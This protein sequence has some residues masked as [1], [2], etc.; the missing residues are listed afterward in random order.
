VLDYGSAD[1]DQVE[2]RPG[3]DIFILGQAAEELLFFMRSKVFADVGDLRR[4]KVL[5]NRI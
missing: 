5:K 1:S 4:P 2:G 3:E